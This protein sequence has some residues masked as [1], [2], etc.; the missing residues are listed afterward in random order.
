M[1][2][3]IGDPFPA[4]PPDDFAILRHGAAEIMLRCSEPPGRSPPRQHDWHVYLRLEDLP[5]RE[6]FAEL[7]R[8]G[9]VARRLERMFYGL[10]ESEITDP[11]G[12]TICLSQ[13]LADAGDLP[14]P[15]PTQ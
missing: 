11:N 2:G 8:R 7:S 5:F 15:T 13:A 4:T 14:T 6:L 10:A 1:L 9:V 12:F 3:L